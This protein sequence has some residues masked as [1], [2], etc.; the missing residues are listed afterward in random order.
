MGMMIMVFDTQIKSKQM[1]LNH[2]AVM[3]S[4]TKILG[5]NLW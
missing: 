2:T 3:L 1:C 5:I 4:V